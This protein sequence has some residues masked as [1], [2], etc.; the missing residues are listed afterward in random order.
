MKLDTWTN[1]W[2]MMSACWP[3][4]KQVERPE[5]MEVYF[6]LLEPYWD[7]EVVRAV[8]DCMRASTFFPSPAELTK[9]LSIHR[10]LLGGDWDTIRKGLECEAA[11]VPVDRLDGPDASAEALAKIPGI[12]RIGTEGKA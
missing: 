1:C 3:A 4:A 2:V 11:G 6:G 10:G 8:K 12:D 9:Y 7:H 5:S